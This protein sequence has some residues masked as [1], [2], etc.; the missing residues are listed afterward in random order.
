MR[1][2]CSL[3][4]RIGG[5][6]V[7]PARRK[8]RERRKKLRATQKGNEIHSEGNESLG[9]ESLV[10]YCLILGLS[11]GEAM[12]FDF[13][14][15]ELLPDFQIDEGLINNHILLDPFQGAVEGSDIG[16]SSLTSLDNQVSS[17]LDQDFNARLD[18]ALFTQNNPSYDPSLLQSWTSIS[19]EAAP[20]FSDSDFISHLG[21]TPDLANHLITVFF[22]KVQGACP[23]FH[24]PSFN[25][26][27]LPSYSSPLKPEDALVLN[28]VFALSSRF[29]TFGFH[30]SEPARDRGRL[31]AAN[32]KK[33]IHESFSNF[34]EFTSDMPQLKCLQGCILLT[35]YLLASSAGSQ[36]WMMTGL[37]CRMAYE[38]ELDKIDVVP[39]TENDVVEWS[40]K[41][42]LR[43]AW[44]GVWELD[45]IASSLA[46]RPFS[47]N[48]YDMSVYL[49]VSDEYWFSN[50]FVESVVIGTDPLSTW[51]IL[52]T[53]PNQDE[54]AWYLAGKSFL[55][56]AQEVQKAAITSPERDEIRNA[57]R[58]FQLALPKSFNLPPLRFDNTNFAAINWVINTHLVLE[59]TG[60]LL[61]MEPPQSVSQNNISVA[62]CTRHVRNITRITRLWKPEFIPFSL[63]F[64]GNLLFGPA[65]INIRGDIAEN[66]GS[67]PEMVK[68]VIGCLSEFWGLG[69]LLLDIFSAYENRNSPTAPQDANLDR[70]LVKRLAV[71]MPENLCR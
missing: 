69:K 6:C 36:S 25:K 53:S 15:H 7:Y 54:R 67:E 26:T 45:G 52:Q 8:P 18:P 34:D 66:T 51:K 5:N 65:G 46:Q 41:E 10:S 60:I 47:I 20:G 31:F 39:T 21:V 9:N 16:S 59:T 23:L 64:V 30:T 43:R 55:K 35:Y 27:F 24:R 56:S 29:A 22:E 33:I 1:P 4:I 44:W 68:L 19:T 17:Q 3:C 32:A 48:R 28:G 38:M 49:P 71:L 50:H 62:Q 2:S 13:M 58:L 12:E 70:G 42:E 57:L 40:R 37:C 61:C 14:M 11:I 63:P